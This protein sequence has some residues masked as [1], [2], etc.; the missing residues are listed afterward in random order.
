MPTIIPKEHYEYLWRI[1]WLS[2]FSTIYGIYRAHYNV[3][4]ITG[5]IW[6]SSI[7][8]WYYPDYSWRRY[9]DMAVAYTGFTAQVIFARNSEYAIV[10]Y[11]LICTAMM[12]YPVGVCFYKHE[13]IWTSVICHS[14]VHIFGN[15]VSIVLI[16][17]NLL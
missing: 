8:Y 3:S 13:H 10:Y 7:N 1:S 6:I 17:G 9:F 2:L 12:F 5:S 4:I 16:S 11:P 15:I 14:M